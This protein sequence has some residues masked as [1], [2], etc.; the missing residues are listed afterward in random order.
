MLWGDWLQKTC[1]K[2]GFRGIKVDNQRVL[3]II[4]ALFSGTKRIVCQKL[5]K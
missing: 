2:M 5:K 1:Q 4:V 3:V